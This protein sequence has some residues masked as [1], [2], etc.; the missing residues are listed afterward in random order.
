[1]QAAKD[2][3]G[4]L[5]GASPMAITRLRNEAKGELVDLLTLQGGLS[6]Q[7]KCRSGCLQRAELGRLRGYPA[8]TR[9][10]SGFAPPQD[11]TCG[12]RDQ[13][14]TRN[15]RWVAGT[16]QPCSC[17]ADFSGRTACKRKTANR[18]PRPLC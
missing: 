1:M 13:G 9:R 12:D 4:G 3:I 2:F 17:L 15:P 11:D 7:S 14:F 5:T 8:T 6:G 16:Q 10:L 18:R